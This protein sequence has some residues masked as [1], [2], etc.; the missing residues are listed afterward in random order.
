MSLQRFAV[1]IN[2]SSALLLNTEK[3]RRL[4]SDKTAELRRDKRIGTENTANLLA[5]E[6]R[7]TD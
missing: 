7:L 1:A 4:K 3:K 2:K 6:Q 5:T